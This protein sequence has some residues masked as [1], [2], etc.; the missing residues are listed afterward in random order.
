MRCHKGKDVRAA[1]MGCGR[2]SLLHE[3][4]NSRHRA[5]QAGLYM[6]CLT[7]YCI[8]Y[9]ELFNIRMINIDVI[10][11]VLLVLLCLSPI[12]VLNSTVSYGQY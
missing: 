11:I 6:H 9:T 8:V 3:G 10:I 4:R 12:V 5:A 2:S 7:Y 1:E